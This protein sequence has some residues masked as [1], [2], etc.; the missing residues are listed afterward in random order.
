MGTVSG[1]LPASPPLP[2]S[3]SILLARSRPP[4]P[5]GQCYDKL[6]GRLFRGPCGPVCS[7][8]SLHRPSALSFSIPL[9]PSPFPLPAPSPPSPTTDLPQPTSDP[10]TRSRRNSCSVAFVLLRRWPATS[11]RA[12]R[13]G[14]THTHTHTH[15]L[16]ITSGWRGAAE[17]AWWWGYGGCK[18]L[19]ASVAAFV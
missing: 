16:S 17:E 12:L 5:G 1:G 13:L 11:A 7:L 4:C 19:S 15:T 2:S 6:D 10:G 18:P 3:V 8:T 9:P 14:H